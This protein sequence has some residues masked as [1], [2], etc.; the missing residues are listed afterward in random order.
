MTDLT[1][2][3]LTQEEQQSALVGDHEVTTNV[4]NNEFNT[5]KQ[6]VEQGKDTETT[7]ENIKD[8]ATKSNIANVDLNMDAKN[9]EDASKST[10]GKNTQ[11]AFDGEEIVE[12]EEEKPDPGTSKKNAEDILRSL[13][14]DPST[15][16]ING[17][18]FENM[19]Q[20]QTDDFIEKSAS[21][22]I[23]SGTEEE[24]K[25]PLKQH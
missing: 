24:K 23:E 22:N 20:A 16:I 13:R 3:D 1:E 11:T 2:T 21:T 19:T 17:T 7:E 25:I 4:D 5:K 12:E 18:P 14:H 10:T 6:A 8:L 9:A 15:A